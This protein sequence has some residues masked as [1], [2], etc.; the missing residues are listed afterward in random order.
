MMI[1]RHE[2][3]AALGLGD[4]HEYTSSQIHKAYLKQAKQT[5]PDSNPH[6]PT[7][8]QSFQRLSE[9]YHSLLTHHSAHPGSSAEWCNDDDLGGTGTAADCR[10]SAAAST[11]E[12]PPYSVDEYK[13]MYEQWST[14]ASDFWNHSS[15]AK[16][17]KHMWT[18]FIE[19]AAK[20]EAQPK[21]AAS[22]PP[23]ATTHSDNTH[24]YP[25]KPSD[26][27]TR[28]CANTTTAA[29]AAL[30]GKD[31]DTMLPTHIDF[32]LHLPLE[33]IYKGVAQKL[34]Y[35]R[36]EWCSETK[37]LQE[38]QCSLLIHTHYKHIVFYN[39]GHQCPKTMRYG[40]VAVCIDAQCTGPFHIDE[41]TQL[42]HCAVR[43][44]PPHHDAAHTTT[45]V[46]I[47]DVFG[48]ELFFTVSEYEDTYTFP[49][50]GLYNVDTQDRNELV[51][52]IEWD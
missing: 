27:H 45:S 24:D 48:E 26:T 32:T 19:H 37:C 25:G 40:N 5:H 51:V 17:V 42:L 12:A 44:P 50:K 33:D 36:H 9:C 8:T 1:T 14:R 46:Q 43:V 49:K 4:T 28:A 38:T 18:H 34:S 7:A 21:T 23:R 16:L 10:T 3:Y 2:C 11:T 47:I 31:A 6:D 29:A 13:R 22:A 41:D 15:E 35:Q 20:A 52:N 30:N 39:E